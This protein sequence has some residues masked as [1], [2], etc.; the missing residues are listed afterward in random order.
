[1]NI[2]S[3]SGFFERLQYRL[4][5]HTRW[6]DA[7]THVNAFAAM[8]SNDAIQRIYVINLDRKPDRW[9]QV[10]RELRRFRDR[11]GTPLS[12]ITRRFS[13]IDARYLEGAPDD[14]TL[15]PSYS[16]ADQLLV[17]PNPLLR[18]DAKSRAQRIEMTPQEVAVALSHIEVWKLIVASNVPYTLVLEDDVYFRHGFAR[19]LDAAWLALL[20]QSSENATFDLLYLSFKEVGIGSQAK[21][22]PTG[23]VR[24]PNAGIWQASGYVLSQAGA[25]KL[26][27]LL[28]THGPIDLWLNLQFGKINVLTTQHSIIEQRIDVSSTNSYSV[29]PVLSQVGVL[30]REKPLVARAQELP[31]PVFAYGE[32]GSGLT[33][34]ATALSMLGYTCC[35]DLHELPAKEQG[36]LLAKRRDRRFNAYVNIGSL[37][38]QSLTTIAKLYP[39]ARF[40]VT[41]CD[42]AQLL[43]L[44]P[45]RVLY[46]P[47]EHRDKWSA[48][49]A[50]LEREY[51]ALPYPAC[52]DVGQRDITNRN[53]EDKKALAFRRLKFDSS[54][55]IVSSKKWH[56][57]AVAEMG[58]EGDFKAGVIQ[59]WSG[60]TALDESLWKLRDDTFPSNLALFTPDNF[61]VDAPLTTKLTL[62]EELTHVR[63]LTSAA[64]ASRQKFLYGTFAA[65]LRPSNVS[66]LITG[67]FLH[68]NGP[69]QE[70]D[71][72]FLGKDTTKMLVNVYYNPG[73]EGTK[74]EYGYRG[75]P[76]LIEL[77]FDAAEVFH[78][79]EIEWH[80]HTIRWRVDGYVVHER[81][82]WNPTP[83]PNLPMEFNVNLW[84]SRS[85]EL[86]GK[87]DTQ[88]IPAHTGI[89]SVRITQNDY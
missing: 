30:T 19:S 28:P 50:F 7:K 69:R 66:G 2:T 51:P 45:G 18:V 64:I 27:E 10:S 15:Q 11:S 5:L 70:I 60:G 65:E 46:L 13:A 34:L 78:R 41:T 55:W 25:R 35:S 80:T 74:L 76:T 86:A 26:L 14:K 58:Q 71:I 79:Y 57:I 12:L 29:M 81:V 53:D 82:L 85:K 88:R 89:K 3:F 43:A 16:L 62:R 52:K 24:R 39:H 48:L 84:H 31:G 73:I 68:R 42:N 38:G 36:S 33:A 83:I 44:P 61:T 59:T 32:P 17:E 63:S 6:L 47:D 54:P 4:S 37:S 87:L 49:S 8:E 56:G 75:T 67:M 40:I 1:M 9:H 72:E 77:G 21:K 20:H 23:P 22:Q